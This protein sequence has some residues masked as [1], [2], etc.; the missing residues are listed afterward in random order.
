[1]KLCRIC[2][3]CVDED[4]VWKKYRKTPAYKEGKYPGWAYA[5]NILDHLLNFHRLPKSLAGLLLT[6]MSVGLW[7]RER[8]E[9]EVGGVEK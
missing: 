6:G 9:F 4:D 5:E 2:K 1:M 3:V 8:P 7:L